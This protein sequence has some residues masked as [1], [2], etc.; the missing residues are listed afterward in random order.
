MRTDITDTWILNIDKCRELF[1]AKFTWYQNDRHAFGEV[2][3][4]EKKDSIKIILNLKK[5]PFQIILKNSLCEFITL[6][7]N[8]VSLYSF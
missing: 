4:T 2:K 3:E 8:F 1:I 5:L 7:S 6:L